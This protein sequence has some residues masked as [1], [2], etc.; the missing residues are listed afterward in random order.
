MTRLIRTLFIMGS[1][2]IVALGFYLY[3]SFY[4]KPVVTQELED[5]YIQIPTGATY[6]QVKDLLKEKG[7]QIKDITFDKT[8]DYMNYIKDPMRSGRYKIEKGWTMV[9]LIRHLRSGKQ[10]PVNVVLTNE[11]LIEDVAGKA[12][13][14][15]EPDSLDILQALKDPAV[16]EEIGYTNESLMSLFIPNTYELYWNT[17]PRQFV[18]RMV[19]EHK[20]FW[21]R[22]NRLNKAKKLDMTTNEVYTLASIVEKETLRNEE[23]KRMAG[24]YLNRLEQGMRLQA[25]PTAVFATRDFDTPRVT[26]YHT[27]FD[28]PYN[29]YMYAGLPPGPISMA[30][31]GSI[32][33]VLNAESHDYLYFCAV[34][35]GS[36]MHNFARTLAQHNRNAQIY[37]DNLRRRGLR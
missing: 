12:A 2:I 33:A 26:N 13:K 25:D 7:V 19:R 21:N 14:Y 34:G 31:I 20:L 15:L 1:L 8:A 23:R 6:E 4:K 37:R 28:S 32:D 10:A 29:T 24:V 11:R 22:E 30:S 35:D 18:E 17:T 5:P 36:G 9:E 16:L 27:Q 3:Q